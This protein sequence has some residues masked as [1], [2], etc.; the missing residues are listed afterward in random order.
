M[1]N[2]GEQ[3][4]GNLIQMSD[5]KILQ[6]SEKCNE[7]VKEMHSHLFEKFQEKFSVIIG[8]CS[9]V[10]FDTNPSWKWVDMKVGSGVSVVGEASRGGAENVC[11]GHGG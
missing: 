9:A 11:D 3:E 5:W 1:A 10:M 6:L 7:E 8:D 4:N 2:G